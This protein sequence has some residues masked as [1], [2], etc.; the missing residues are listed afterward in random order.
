MDIQTASNPT[1]LTDAEKKHIPVIEFEETDIIVK[2]GQTNHP[3][4]EDHFIE[5]IELY[6]NGN[7]YSRKNLKPGRKPKAA[8]HD[9][10]ESGT[11]HSVAH[12]NQHGS[13]KS[14]DVQL[15]DY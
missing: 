13:W 15:S 4:E 11:L 12:C 2:I 7:L 8:F 9:V 3:M 14:E 5:W 1:K 6:L 10:L